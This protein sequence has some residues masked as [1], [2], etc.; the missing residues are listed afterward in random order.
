MRAG[1]GDPTSRPA[2]PHQNG[3][4]AWSCTLACPGSQTETDD[5]RLKIAVETSENWPRS[6]ALVLAAPRPRLGPCS[7]GPYR[8]IRAF[9]FA[10]GMAA[11]AAFHLVEAPPSVA[12]SVALSWAWT[13]ETELRRSR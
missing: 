3:H 12:G 8:V 6:R 13:R 5:M 2:C 9:P 1:M 7:F 10:S 4:G 11:W